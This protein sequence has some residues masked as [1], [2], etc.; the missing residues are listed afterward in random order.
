MATIAIDFDGVI[1]SYE[2]GWA[3]GSIYGDF[4]P[5]AHEALL[6][7]MD[8]YAVFVHTTRNAR[9]VAAWIE[10]TSGHTI[11]CVTTWQHPSMWLPWRSRF[12]DTKGLLLVTN[13]KLPALVYID[14]RAL[15]FESWEQARAALA[16]LGIPTR[17][18]EE[19]V[20]TT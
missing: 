1:H 17:P 7:L 19:E 6:Q 10:R 4:K 9:A 14:D 5:G 16:L 8:R 15:R 2:R 12:W 13:R 20:R 3:D 18:G 11:E